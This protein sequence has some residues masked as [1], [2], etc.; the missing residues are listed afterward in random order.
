MT[1]ILK[2]FCIHGHPTPGG[3]GRDRQGRCRTCR[4]EYRPKRHAEGKWINLVCWEDGHRDVYAYIPSDPWHAYDPN[5]T[6][7]WPGSGYGWPD[8]GTEFRVT[9]TAASF[10][11]DQRDA[12][13]LRRAIL[14]E[15]V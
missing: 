14:G 12:V 6:I 5:R 1:G 4:G 7:G 11:A 15:V 3:K 9:I 8:T 13:R 2:A 10:R